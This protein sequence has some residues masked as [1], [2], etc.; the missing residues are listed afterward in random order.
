MKV[1]VATTAG[2]GHFAGLRPFARACAQAGHEVRVA[3]AVVAAVLLLRGRIEGLLLGV[4]LLVLLWVLAP[5]AGFAV[6][7]TAATC[8][9]VP[10]LR[11]LHLSGDA[12]GG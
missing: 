9:L 2:A 3:A 12:R 7:G 1:L 11:R 5:I 4:P 6:L 10:T 8:L